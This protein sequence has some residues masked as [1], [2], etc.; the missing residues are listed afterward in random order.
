M[1]IRKNSGKTFSFNRLNFLE[2]KGVSIGYVQDDAQNEAELTLGLGFRG[3][4]WYVNPDLGDDTSNTGLSWDS[5]FATMSK[6]F[7]S[8]DS[9]DTVFFYGKV[10]EQLTCP[11]QKFDVT[12][13]GASNRPRHADA[14]PVGSEYGATWTTT[15]V[16]AATTPLV[17]V[18][19]QGWRFVNILFAGP[20][21]SASVLLF[22]DG[23]AG[24]AERDASHA[25]II[26]C[27]FASGKNGIESSGGAYNVGIYDCSFHDLTDYAIKHTAGAGIAASYR[28]QIKGNR[29]QGNAKWIDT[30]NGN[31]WEITDNVVVKTTT[32][33]LVTSGGT[34]GNAIVRN[35]FNI[36]AADFDPAGGFTGHATDVWSN[37]LT[38]AIETGLPAN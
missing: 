29:F 31:S 28:W 24:N 36:A 34:G 9:G 3:T 12:I 17:K 18:M 4:F 15:A 13:V 27:R 11:V 20:S 21:N 38:D 1:D 8:L 19:Q 16:E 23:G 30:F 37:Y 25:E 26:G 32:P 22:R 7:T 5:P 33:G 6:A 14:A 2:G 35:V 10:K